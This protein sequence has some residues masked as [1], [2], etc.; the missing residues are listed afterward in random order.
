MHVVIVLAHWTT[1]FTYPSQQYANANRRQG[2]KSTSDPGIMYDT[3]FNEKNR[4]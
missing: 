3:P 4:V 2:V 1:V